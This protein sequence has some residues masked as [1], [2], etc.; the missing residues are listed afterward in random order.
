MRR[1]V[2]EIDVPYPPEVLEATFGSLADKSSHE[3]I[4]VAV[5]R[6]TAKDDFGL[7]TR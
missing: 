6:W 7:G 2:I 3:P 4:T 5:A 1:L